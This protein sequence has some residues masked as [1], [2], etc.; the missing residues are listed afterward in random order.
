MRWAGATKIS[1]ARRVGPVPSP[2]PSPPD[3]LWRESPGGLP[4]DPLRVLI[5]FH[6]GFLQ[7]WQHGYR[8]PE[9]FRDH[10]YYGKAREAVGTFHEWTAGVVQCLAALLPDLARQLPDD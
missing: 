2:P 8:W 9:P 6:Q 1:G 10:V 7:P 3:D 5:T 4:G